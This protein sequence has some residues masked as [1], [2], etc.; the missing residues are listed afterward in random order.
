MYPSIV[1]PPDYTSGPLTL[2]EA[3]GHLRVDHSEEDQD[4]EAKLAEATATVARLVGR[5]LGPAVYDVLFDRWPGCDELCLPLPP[6]RGVT[7]V[8]YTLESGASIVLPTTEYAVDIK[9]E[10]GRVVLKPN[11]TWPADT[12]WP[13]NPIAIRIDC[14]YANAAAV[15][16]ELKAAIKLQLGH[17]Y[18][19]REDVIVGNSAS[20]ESRQLAGG[21]MDLIDEFRADRFGA[22]YLQR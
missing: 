17:L 1:T 8:T 6:L 5:P 18:L 21:V 9:Q 19:H 10:P 14:G 7:T 16:F 12:L 22:L 4:I 15:P 3:K 20:A 13:V 2:A 11:R